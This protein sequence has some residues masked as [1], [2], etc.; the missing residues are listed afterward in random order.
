MT[1]RLTDARTLDGLTNS[2]TGLIL[3]SSAA[4]S[5]A[6]SFTVDNVFKPQ[7][8]SFLFVIHTSGNTGAVTMQFRAGGSTTAT[9]YARQELF[10]GSTSVTA[11]RSSSQTSFS[12]QNLS[13]GGVVVDIL[14]PNVATPTS[15][16]ARGLG[17]GSFDPAQPEISLQFGGQVDATAF[18]G[19]IATS[20]FANALTGR[21]YIFGYRG[22]G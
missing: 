1:E 5:S 9:G 21:Y 16:I 18:D 19:L 13:V 3:L 6:T 8:S 4:L 12:F 14:K 7:F 11:S 2:R 15:V 20:Q 22:N 17:H 10:A